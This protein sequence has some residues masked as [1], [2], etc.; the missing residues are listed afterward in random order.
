MSLFNRDSANHPLSN[1]PSL[2]Q[3]SLAQSPL[4]QLQQSLNHYWQLPFHSD[5]NLE[6]KLQQV[7]DWQ[8]NRINQTHSE[9]FSLPQNKAMADYFV[10]DLYAG[11]DFQTIAQQLELIIAKAKPIEK[12]IPHKA[13]ETGTLGI[14]AAIEAI[15]LDLHIAQWL[16]NHQLDVTPDTMYTAYRAVNAKS[17]RQH[18][19]ASM[20]QV[21][22]QTDKYINSFILQKSFK[23]AKSIAYKQ[24][25]QPLYDFIAHGFEAMKQLDT[26]A[27]F[28]EPVAK[29]ELAIIEQV[30]NPTNPLNP[31]NNDGKITP[32]SLSL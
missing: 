9:L 21:C 28:I 3:S 12:L 18:Q 32:F 11:Q 27:S 14:K 29:R 4:T 23:L 22:Y 24:G 2:A 6:Q 16:L 7:Q 26:V 31:L 30:H 15:E 5:I 20:Q 8:R 25:L 1:Q 13:L 10:N 17:A 19:I